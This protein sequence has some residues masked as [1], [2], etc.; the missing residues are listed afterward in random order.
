MDHK[1]PRAALA[2]DAVAYSD[3]C[4]QLGV[5]SSYLFVSHCYVTYVYDCRP[6]VAQK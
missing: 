3:Q 5:F 2:V 6:K 1:T 4:V